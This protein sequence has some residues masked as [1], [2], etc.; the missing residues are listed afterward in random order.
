MAPLSNRGAR[1]RPRV[2]YLALGGTIASVH[3]DDQLGAAPTLSAAE[4]AKS[5]PDI[6]EQF[7]LRSEQF[8]Q[9]SSPSIALADLLR[10]R[11]ELLRRVAAGTRGVVITQ[12]TDTVEETAYVLDLLWEADAPIVISGA[13][14]NPSLPGS[15]GPANLLAAVQVAASDAAR[16]L[17]V[18]V[19]FN[20]EIHAAR[21]VRKTH[22]SSPS[23]FR[24]NPIG[25][26][27]WL[28]EGRVF[29]A[30]RPVDRFHIAV[31]AD[32]AV[33]P[34]ALVKLG[35]GDDGRILSALPGL[36]YRGVVLEAFGG[37]HVAPA[38]MEFLAELVE[39]L[40]VVLASRT[41]AGE[42]LSKTYRFRGSEI[43]LIEL[44]LIRAGSLD[45]IKA[46]LLLSLCLAAGDSRTGII[47]AFSTAGMTSGPVARIV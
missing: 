16:G 38:T 6:D 9:V 46:R 34:V 11:D 7:D 29:I 21:F 12:G 47:E 8:L 40:P 43:E 19:V 32:A 18:I 28:S 14:R 30:T 4:I 31:P 27:G 20:D 15:D 36:D 3:S 5:V 41:G 37:G 23:T 22:T 26:V 10:L 39:R 1:S 33:P 24:S 44:G 2:D 42:V 35:L 25:P 17:G 13:M 45:G